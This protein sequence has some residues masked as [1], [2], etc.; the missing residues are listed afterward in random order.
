MTKALAV[1]ESTEEISCLD[2]LSH[3]NCYDVIAILYI[4]LHGAEPLHMREWTRHEMLL[5][6]SEHYEANQGMFKLKKQYW[7]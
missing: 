4:D 1:A 6:F 2:V 7:H 5:W 3:V